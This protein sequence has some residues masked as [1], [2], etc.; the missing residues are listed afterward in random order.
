MVFDVESLRA[1][2]EERIETAE[3]RGEHRVKM[4]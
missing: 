4:V 1:D 2:E 3:R